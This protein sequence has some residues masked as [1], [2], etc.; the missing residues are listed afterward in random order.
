LT[1]ARLEIR[2]SVRWI[3][4]VKL[5]FILT[6]I[7]AVRN[8]FGLFFTSIENQFGLTRAETSAFFSIFSILAAFFTVLGGWALD[9]FGPKLVFIVMG[10]I[11]ILSLVLTG[12]TTS[13]WELYL[14][15]SLLLAAGTGGG[16]SLTL[17]AVSKLFTKQRGLALGIALSGEGVGTLAIAP[18]ATFLI[19]SFNWRVA[20]WIIGP[21]AGAIVIGLALFLKQL[22][23]HSESPSPFRTSSGS[24]TP[25]FTVL[26]AMKTTSF[27]LLGTVYLTLS[28]NYYLA[29]TH[30][31]PDAIDLGIT[32]ARAAII[33][34]LIGGFTIPGRLVIG[35]ASD[36]INRKKLAILCALIEVLTMI[37][38][39]WSS[40]FWMFCVFAVVF[41]FT[42]G[43]LSNLMATLI[44]DT[45]G[46]ANIG[47]MTGFLVV[48]FTIGAAMGPALGGI[49]YDSMGSYFIAFLTGIGIAGLAVLCL[50]LTK[51][52]IKAKLVKP[53]QVETS[54]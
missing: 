3:E 40:S 46:M 33:V 16:F 43:G 53:A 35:W 9:K 8:S 49:I 48:G 54:L 47:T 51:R 20:Y 4:L 18:I 13:S 31:V 27:W 11:T 36:R 42:F 29:L 6:A 32:A 2:E 41:G 17:A 44:G 23:R 52:E 15:Y 25:S 14:T 5:L 19:T 21:V 12:R 37:W 30:I 1:T 50:T 24:P 22:P 7:M 26:E 28:F 38:L 45:F 39:L 34:S 10:A